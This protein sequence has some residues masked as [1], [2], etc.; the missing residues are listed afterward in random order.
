M[1]ASNHRRRRQPVKD[2]NIRRAVTPQEATK[3]MKIVATTL[4]LVLSTKVERHVS[5]CPQ[6]LI[7]MNCGLQS[8][9]FTDDQ[10]NLFPFAK[11]KLISQGGSL[12]EGLSR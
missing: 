8:K 7:N 5:E 6:T 2:I 12:R 3:T 9:N 1:Q 11:L 4:R 10:Y